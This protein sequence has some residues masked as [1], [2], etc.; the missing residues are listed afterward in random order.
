VLS[1]LD[2]SAGELVDR[3]PARSLAVQQHD[4]VGLAFR[5]PEAGPEPRRLFALLGAVDRLLVGAGFGRE[6]ELPQ[7][8]AE[9]ADVLSTAIVARCSPRPEPMLRPTG[10][11][12][13]GTGGAIR[14][15]SAM[16]ATPSV[17][18]R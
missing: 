4:E 1:D 13:V 6:L 9:L 15:T 3:G 12:S 11:G 14:S 17:N 18:R 8:F 2:E 7:A 5:R 10:D 16:A